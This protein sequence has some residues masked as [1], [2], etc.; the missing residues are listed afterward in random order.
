MAA[1]HAAIQ[2]PPRLGLIGYGR[3]GKNLYRELSSRAQ[4]LN[5][6]DP[7]LTTG[8][9][10]QHT[11]SLYHHKPDA[12][13]IA[14]STSAHFDLALE[15]LRHGCDVFV[16]KPLA[17]TLERSR[18]LT[19]IAKA[20]SCTLFVDHLA[21]FQPAV[22]AL[23][24]LIAIHGPPREVR[25]V[26]TAQQGG[27]GPVLWDLMVHDL[28][29]LDELLGFPWMIRPEGQGALLER[30]DTRAHLVVRYSKERERRWT[31]TW[32]H[33]VAE[34]DELA[35]SVNGR[36]VAGPSPLFTSVGTFLTQLG[37]AD[38]REAER[39]VRL[40]ALLEAIS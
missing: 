23:R 37:Q 10:T 29:L 24:E 16:E 17:D 2:S 3:W 5:V 22:P 38:L 6:V 39:A 36:V 7:V 4:I 26:R 14:A 28:S 31:L 15:A 9:D 18:R 32:D 8:S 20:R 1:P 30:G 34:Y 33:F 12:V 21:C 19:Q 27:G 40:A 25:A 35:Q 11:R 13:A